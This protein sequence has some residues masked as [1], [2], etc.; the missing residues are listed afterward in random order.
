MQ[1][2]DL[3]AK[4]TRSI[5]QLSPQDLVQVAALIESLASQ[6]TLSSPSDQAIESRLQWVER[7]RLNRSR[8]SVQSEQQTVV[9]IRQDTRY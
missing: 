5:P 2:T 8:R 3:Q 4:I 1:I 9:K 6:K 7:L